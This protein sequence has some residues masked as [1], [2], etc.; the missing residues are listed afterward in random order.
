MYKSKC[1]SVLVKGV[2]VAT[3][4]YLRVEFKE[5]QSCLPVEYAVPAA[6]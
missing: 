1:V 2:F 6:G 3:I 4:E 5:A